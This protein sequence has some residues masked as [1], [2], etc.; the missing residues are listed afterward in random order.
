M[1]LIEPLGLLHGPAAAQAVDAGLALPLAGGPAAF[2]LARLIEPGAADRLVGVRDIQA[3]GIQ[4]DWIQEDWRD[5]ARRIADAPSPWAGL[6][7]DR[8]AIMGIL[9]V[10][11]DSFSD[12]GTYFDPT[13]F[14]PTL[15][16]AAGHAM[17]ADGADILDVGGES[18][19]PKAEPVPPEAEQARILPVI[20]ALAAAGYRVSVDTRNAATMAAAL[21]A[22]ARIVNDVS[23]LTHDP[24]AADLVARRGC[25]VVLMHMRGTP[26]DMQ[27]RTQYHHPAYEILDELA[28]SRDH[29][30]RA[31]IAAH[32][33]VIDPGIGFAKNTSQNRELL[34]RV[35]LFTNLGC[36]I[37]LGVSRK[38]L[39]G[40]INQQPDPLRRVPG[41]LAAGLFGLA[42]GAT[43]LRTHDVMETKQAM[44]TWDFL[45]TRNGEIHTTHGSIPPLPP[46]AATDR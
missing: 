14:D 43:L 36:R 35:S 22:G 40:R 2:T 20:R 46:R 25:P 42:G 6:P 23:A 37:M 10:T 8:P 38:S 4:E 31:G 7:T 30:I 33:I 16:I 28:A 34:Y 39:I 11:P 45:Q 18:T 9:N 1:R 5:I 44:H 29:A 21:D 3:D 15:A 24:R 27:S 17:A 19:R 41:S 26:A 32:N 13:R 12:A